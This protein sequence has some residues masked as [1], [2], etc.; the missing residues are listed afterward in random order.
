MQHPPPPRS[1]ET[2]FALA[3]HGERLPSW[4]AIEAGLSRSSV[5]LAVASGEVIKVF[6]TD[7]NRKFYLACELRGSTDLVRGVAWANGAM[8][9]Y[10]V[11]AGACKDGLVRIWE[12][13]TPVVPQRRPSEEHSQD[14]GTPQ[15]AKARSGIGAGLAEMSREGAGVEREDPSRVRQDAK[16]VAELKGHRGAVWRVQ[17]S[18]TGEVLMSTGD[19]GVVRTWKRDTNRD[20]AEYAAVDVEDLDEDEGGE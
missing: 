3:W 2:S 1:E 18:L 16:C 13:R 15:R 19:D 10:D 9:G 11:I 5:G 17:F 12:V 14:G 20:W 6:R 4:R 7:A 8:R